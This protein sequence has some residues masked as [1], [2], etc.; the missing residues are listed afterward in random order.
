MQNTGKKRKMFTVMPL[1]N[2]NETMIIGPHDNEYPWETGKLTFINAT[3]L[4]SRSHSFADH[5]NANEKHTFLARF[6]RLKMFS[7]KLQRINEKTLLEDEDAHRTVK[8]W[9]DVAGD[10][11][12]MRPQVLEGDAAEMGAGAKA[13]MYISHTLDGEYEGAKLYT[14]NPGASITT[15]YL[16]EN[17]QLLKRLLMT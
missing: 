12:Y 5:L 1:L 6:K 8:H 11:A 2:M 9:L 15:E 10:S 13:V 3:F 4:S 16:E 17:V 14:P 7:D